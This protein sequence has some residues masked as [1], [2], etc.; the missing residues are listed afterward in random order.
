MQTLLI[1]LIFAGALFYLGRMVYLSF[2][3]KSGCVTGCAKCS[4]VDLNKKSTL[5][6]NS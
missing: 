2:Q 6:N 5:P 3:S 4:V 1:V